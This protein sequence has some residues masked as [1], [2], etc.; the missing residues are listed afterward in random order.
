MP[1]SAPGKDGPLSGTR[2]LVTRSPERSAALVQ[3]LAGAG[4]TPVLLPLIDFERAPDQHAL[5]VACDALAAGAFDWLV[6]SSA[7]TVH[8]LMEK[9]AERG[10]ELAR[11]VPPATRIGAIGPATRRILESHGLAVELTPAGEQSAAGLLEA[12]T[13]GGRVLLPQ[14]DIAAA[15]LADGLRKGSD[16]TAVTFYRTVDFPA[17]A[18]RR[19]AMQP[20]DGGAGQATASYTLLTPEAAAAEIAGGR[21]SA[22]VAASPSAVRRIASLSPLG[23][24]RLVAIGRS[25]ADQAAALDLPVAAVAD[26]P[27]PDGLVAAVVKALT[28]P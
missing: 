21:I 10:L 20:E 12:W 11:L 26:E 24:C 7:T 22:V 18:D 5:D 17:A 3:A 16:V 2:V 13:G 6:V 19:L 25:T 8:V 9:A 23:G 14:A 1:S 15:T 27:T 28:P 4:A